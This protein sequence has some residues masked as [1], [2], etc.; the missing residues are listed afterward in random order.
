VTAE[1]PPIVRRR[2]VVSGRVQG[3]GFRFACARE[4]GRLGLAGWVRNRADG[5][6][7]AA[8]QGPPPEVDLMV[9][10]CAKGPTLARVRH[11]D[12]SEEL[13]ADAQRFELLG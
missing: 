7:E 10:W 4:A 9:A 8:F 5:T 12:V 13:L 1:G 2:V 11:T 3:V 6:V